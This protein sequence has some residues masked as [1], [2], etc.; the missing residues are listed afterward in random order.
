MEGTVQTFMPGSVRNRSSCGQTRWKHTTLWAARSV[1]PSRNFGNKIDKLVSCLR[2][3]AARAIVHFYAVVGSSAHCN[4]SFTCAVCLPVSPVMQHAV[5]LPRAVVQATRLLLSQLLKGQ[6]CAGP[7]Q[8]QLRNGGNHCGKE[9]VGGRRRN[10]W[11]AGDGRCFVLVVRYKCA[12]AT[13]S[14][15]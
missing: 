4:I 12:R 6:T 5:V 3:E 7:G 2:S 8:T 10:Y 15:L 9:K 13:T 1:Q 11:R 14:T